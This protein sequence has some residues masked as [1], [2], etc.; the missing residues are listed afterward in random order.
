[1]S[2]FSDWLHNKP[3][4][5]WQRILETPVKWLVTAFIFI[6]VFTGIVAAGAVFVPIAMLKIGLMI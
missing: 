1:M 3:T 2:K 4:S 6:G 5:R